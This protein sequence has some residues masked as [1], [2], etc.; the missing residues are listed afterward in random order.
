MSLL[1]AIHESAG[2]ED[3]I[4]YRPNGI[5]AFCVLNAGS[6]PIFRDISVDVFHQ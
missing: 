5:V 6:I 3:W 1:R 2:Q 4:I